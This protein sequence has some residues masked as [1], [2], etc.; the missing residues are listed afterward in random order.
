MHISIKKY[1]QKDKKAQVGLAIVSALV[2]LALITPFFT[3]DPDAFSSMI[4]TQPGQANLLGTNDLGQ[5]I[6][7]RLI[8]GLR[9][10]IFVSVGVGILA[11]FI[12][13]I[14]GVF[15]GFIGGMFDIVVMRIVDVFLVMP[16]IIILILISAF[17]RPNMLWLIIIISLL[18]W[19]RGARVIRG[20]TLALKQ[21]AHI[22]SARAFGAKRVYMLVRHIIPDLGNII[23]VSFINNA[24][25]AV[26][27][28]AGVAFI[29]ISSLTT[30]SL[31]TIMHN[32]FK[33]YYLPVWIWWLLPAGILLS[34]ILISLTF[35]GNL[36]EKIIDPR[37]NNA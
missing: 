12:S 7:S 10:S 2:L 28:E 27:L 18:S 13:I 21:R 15:S 17:I 14:A 33:F 24:R 1:L 25:S 6:F 29:G 3:R 20:Q 8:Y 9:T 32:A 23:I 30:I 22:Y 34:A 37:L 31:G 16:S 35:L 11:T 4:F 36:M 5:D 19:Q 26:F